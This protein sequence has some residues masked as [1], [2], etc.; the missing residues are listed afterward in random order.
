MS[1][2]Q[3]TDVFGLAPIGHNQPPPEE[4]L[5]L[6]LDETYKDLAPRLTK[7]VEGF[8]RAPVVITTE[9]ENEDASD[10]KKMFRELAKEATAGQVKEAHGFIVCHRLVLS[11][12]KKNIT[13]P[14]E[15]KM[16]ALGLRKTSYEREKAA[17]ELKRRQTE[18]RR[19]REWAEARAAEAERLLREA[20]KREAEAQ[21]ERDRMVREDAE[22][23]AAEKKEREAREEIEREA[24]REALARANAAKDAAERA[25]AADRN[26]ADEA[27]R[28]E[29][30]A[31]ERGYREA[32][33]R[34][35]V[36][37]R[38]DAAR[39]AAE[40]KTV[41]D[42]AAEAAKKA[43][44][45]AQADAVKA[46]RLA[47]AKASDMSQSRSDL[48]ARS[49]LHTMWVHEP[50]DK[51]CTELVDRDKVD[52]E[53]LRQHLGMDCL[54]KAVNSFVKTGGHRLRGQRIFETTES[55]G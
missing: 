26:R 8:D 40:Q 10:L 28:Q 25:A 44:K 13:T 18:E 23:E 5:R 38:Q 14:S 24:Q 31:L 53:A 1:D 36:R 42:E 22:R 11:F 37:K 48:G 41:D 46:K 29:A 45:L 39:A 16:A 52:L 19:L 15:E 34:E 33:E 7:L 55:R 4:A 49:S 12:F 32:E 21:A 50:F 47:G 54:N 20:A 2:A 43:A 6:R 27:V 51:N 35:A 17:R 3:E 9:K 30:A